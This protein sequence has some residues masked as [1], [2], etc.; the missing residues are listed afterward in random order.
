MKKVILI[1][2]VGMWS[3]SLGW[4]QKPKPTNT[5]SPTQS[6]IKPVEQKS[7]ESASDVVASHFA[8]KYAVASRWNDLDVAK[9]A[10]YDLIIEYPGNDSLIFALAYYYYEQQNNTSVVLVCQDLL[11]RNPKNTSALE[12]SAVAYDILNIRDRALQNFESLFLL[13]NDNMTLYKM[14]FLQYQL[15]KYPECLTNADILLTKPESGTLKVTFNDK[16]NKPKEYAMKVALL[17][18]KGLVYKD[19]ADKVNAKKFLDEALVAAPDFVPA[20][21]T[22]AGLK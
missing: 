10:L 4:S 17:Y 6:Q 20:K 14:A 11:V 15:K 16:D 21:E 9:G 7:A 5:Q 18:L 13:T 12:L 19:Q 1:V 3:L 2:I 22:V 8:K